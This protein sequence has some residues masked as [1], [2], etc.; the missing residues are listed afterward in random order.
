MELSVCLSKL[1]KNGYKPTSQRKAL[2]RLFLENNRTLF[3]AK[4]V[5]E[6]ITHLTGKQASFGNVYHNL[7]LLCI[8]DIIDKTDYCGESF[9]YLKEP[10]KKESVMF[11]CTNCKKIMY[12]SNGLFEQFLKKEKE[13]HA[14]K[15]INQ[16]FEIYG[17]CPECQ[18]SG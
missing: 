4:E 18:L 8:F 9:F 5:R 10:S 14:Y 16:K 7:Y 12:F 1:T 15:V 2:I 3:S 13:E 6:Y 11:I 17:L